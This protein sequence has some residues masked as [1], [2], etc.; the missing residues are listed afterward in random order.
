MTGSWLVHAHERSHEDGLFVYDVEVSGAGGTVFERWQGLRLKAMKGLLPRPSW[1]TPLLGPYLERRVEE[2]LPEARIAIVLD[3]SEGGANAGR[4]VI[5]RCSMLWGNPFAS[6]GGRTA[7]RRRGATA[8]S[9]RPTR[10][11]SRWANEFE[12]DRSLR[13]MR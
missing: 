13:R 10:E 2:V 11:T 6:E 1:V 3:C 8:A 4:A 9:R 5:A 7:N 12:K